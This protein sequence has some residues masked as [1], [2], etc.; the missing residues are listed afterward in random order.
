VPAR[1]S[2]SPS[3]ASPRNSWPWWMVRASQITY[4]DASP[5][6]PDGC[7]PFPATAASAAAEGRRSSCTARASTAVLQALSPPMLAEVTLNS[8]WIVPSFCA[9]LLPL[10]VVVGEEEEKAEGAAAA[11]WRRRSSSVVPSAWERGTT[12]SDRKE[13]GAMTAGFAA[14][15]QAA[16]EDEDE[17]DV[18][19]VVFF[20]QGGGVVDDI[21]IL[22][23][24]SS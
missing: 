18:V 3:G 11:R 7:F 24:C 10:V 12:T 17:E 1:G 9:S 15:T 23:R 21:L 14:A 6:S 8:T 16:E 5:P 20:L 2:L 13:P 4:R 22:K 19:A